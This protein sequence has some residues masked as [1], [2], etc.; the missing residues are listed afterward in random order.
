MKAYF[1]LASLVSRQK[2]P[3]IAVPDPME[4]LEEPCFHDMVLVGCENCG[5]WL[6]YYCNICWEDEDGRSSLDARC[7]CPIP[8]YV[9]PEPK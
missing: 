8:H 5:T 4:E 6:G 2:P 3:S 7:E 1:N 9:P